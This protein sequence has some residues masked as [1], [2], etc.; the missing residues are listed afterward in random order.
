MTDKIPVTLLTGYLGAGKTTLLNRIL[1]Q[2]HGKRFAVI[3]NEF[4]AIGIDSELIVAARDDLYEMS[5][6][7]I[8]CTV[9]GDFNRTLY[10]L[11]RDPRR[12][13]AILVETTGLADPGPLAQI[14]L[15]DH[16]IAM[17]SELDAI[18]TVAD[19]KW[20]LRHLS[21]APETRTQI[22]FADLII[23]NKTDLVGPLEL[24][25]VEARIRAFNRHAD[26][27]RTQNCDLPLDL[28]FERHA[29]DLDR[30]QDIAPL[31]E[32]HGGHH[33]HDHQEGG[34]HAHD[35]TITSVALFHD[36]EVDRE[37]LLTWLGALI[38][39]DGE[40]IL[41]TKGILAFPGEPQRFVL[42]SVYTIVDGILQR[43]WAPGE[44]RQSKLVLIGRDL[45]AEALRGAFRSFA[46][47][48]G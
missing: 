43:P 21:S 13:D 17:F 26:I 31:D 38:A 41:R 25:D 24:D 45:D 42:Q 3:V 7:C 10:G 32:S 23:L 5:N 33:H 44:R 15:D 18:I 39:S 37:R 6:G 30:L 12:F 46:I 8:C 47:G 22:A 14:F 36:G 4:G 28:L 35:D 29:F 27:I 11:M 2:Q 16:M 20:T 48:G 19:A 40:R 9:Q 34:D 1:A